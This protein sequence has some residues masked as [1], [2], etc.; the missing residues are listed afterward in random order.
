MGPGCQEGQVWE[1]TRNCAREPQV[2]GG[3]RWH[4]WERGLPGHVGS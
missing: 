1:H 3:G 4:H 2:G